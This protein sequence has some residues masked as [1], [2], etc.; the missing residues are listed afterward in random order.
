M[1]RSGFRRLHSIAGVVP[2]GAFLAFHLTVS[3]IHT[4]VFAYSGDTLTQLLQLGDWWHTNRPVGSYPRTFVHYLSGQPVS[5][6]IA[7]IGV[8]CSGDFAYNGHWGG[9]YGLTLKNLIIPSSKN[10]GC[11]R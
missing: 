10:G 6:G 2:L 11:L 7:W 5:G 1:D 4:G 9:G 3:E 8:L